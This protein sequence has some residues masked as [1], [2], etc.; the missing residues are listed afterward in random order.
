MTH[1]APDDPTSS[2]LDRIER[3]LEAIAANQLE[4]RARWFSEPGHRLYCL[5]QRQ[6]CG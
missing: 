4:E 2:R 6:S 3:I 1:S 5:K